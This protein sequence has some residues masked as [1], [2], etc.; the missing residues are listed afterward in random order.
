MLGHGG[1]PLP[2]P[3]RRLSLPVP[4]RT[5]N[6]VGNWE[7]LRRTAPACYPPVVPDLRIKEHGRIRELVHGR[8]VLVTVDVILALAPLPVRGQEVE[9]VEGGH[10]RGRS[11]PVCGRVVTARGLLTAT[12][13]DAYALV[14]GETSLDPRI[15][16]GLAG[17]ALG[18]TG[19]G[20]QTATGRVDSVCVPQLAGEIMLTGRG[21]VISRVDGRSCGR[22]PE[23]GVRL[24]AHLA[25][26]ALLEQMTVRR[27]LGRHGRL[28]EAS[29]IVQALVVDPLLLR[30]RRMMTG[31]VPLS[32]LTLTGMTLSGLSWASSGAF[33]AWESLQVFHQLVARLLLPRYMD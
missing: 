20:L 16:T 7:R 32:R 1:L 22:R 29:V 19:S 26:S 6:D 17:T 9:S 23:L 21:H 12:A 27:V 24:G 3:L 30:E 33:M 28:R 2:A 10:R 8:I 11:L 15:D 31:R 18:V 14:L 4:R 25:I 13:L 5:F